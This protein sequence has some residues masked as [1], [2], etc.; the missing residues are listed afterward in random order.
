[1]YV[2][3]HHLTRDSSRAKIPWPCT[4]AT[5]HSGCACK[6]GCLL[7]SLFK[8]EIAVPKAY[9][10]SE[11]GLHKK[12]HM[13]KGTA[14]PK[15]MCLLAELKKDK[16]KKERKISSWIRR[17][18]VRRNRQSSSL[19]P[20]LFRPRNHSM[21]AM[22]D[23][24]GGVCVCTLPRQ[25]PR[26]RARIATRFPNLPPFPSLQPP[27]LP[28]HQSPSQ[29]GSQEHPRVKIAPRAGSTGTSTS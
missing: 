21:E 23:R 11:P 29:S 15:C 10:A 9:V 26:E 18:T 24:S 14:G 13:L 28:A 25:R 17:E 19:R 12:Y 27:P 8:T 16:Q 3:F 5:S 1:M 22:G 2:S 4:C 6:R 20:C 7:T